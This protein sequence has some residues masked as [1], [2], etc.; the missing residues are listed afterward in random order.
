MDRKPSPSPNQSSSQEVDGGHHVVD[1]WMMVHRPHHL[2]E[3]D[4]SPAVAETEPAGAAEGPDDTAQTAVALQEQEDPLLGLLPDHLPIL[5]YDR[6]I[7]PYEDPRS[8]D[9]HL[10]EM[11]KSFEVRDMMDYFLVKELADAQWWINLFRRLRH[12]A[13]TLAER[14]VMQDMLIRHAQDQRSA[15]VDAS[16][17]DDPRTS[18]ILMMK[19]VDDGD[20]ASLADL[21]R[22]MMDASITPEMVT[23]AAHRQAMPTMSILWDLQQELERRSDHITRMIPERHIRMDA[24][25]NALRLQQF[26]FSKFAEEVSKE[27]RRMRNAGEGARPPTVRSSNR[28]THGIFSRERRA[29]RADEAH[30]LAQRMSGTYAHVYPMI[31]KAVSVADAVLALAD[32]RQVLLVMMSPPSASTTAMTR[33]GGDATTLKHIEASLGDFLKVMGY[34]RK[35]S[36]HAAKAMNMFDHLTIEEMRKDQKEIERMK[37]LSGKFDLF[38]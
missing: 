30:D 15:T 27:V 12:V 24:H 7:M 31:N 18:I 21:E 20:H 25:L 9:A 33:E 22:S 23:E 14:D 28:Q 5:M 10:A 1:E 13:V 19:G 35:M 3:T 37:A 38:E 34:M 36:S 16:S 11:I 32:A 6:P 4:A 29:S 17:D 8:Y 26:R 2:Q